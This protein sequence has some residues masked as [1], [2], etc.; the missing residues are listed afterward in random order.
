MTD[1]SL[2]ALRMRLTGGKEVVAETDAVTASQRRLRD[3]QGKFV[4]GSQQS[5]K[6]TEKQAAAQAKLAKT[7]TSLRTVGSAMTKYVS[8]PLA[9]IGVASGVMALDFD[10]SMRNVNSIAQLPEK[11]FISL[12]KQVL[13]LA[14]PTAQAPKTLAEGLYDLV[15]SGFTA[16]E[17]IRILH[18][19][20]LAASAGLTT[21]E[22]STKA[23]AASLNAYHLPAQKA[24]WVS[25]TLFET[26]NR[27]VLTFDELARSIG[28]VLP[29]ASQLNVPLNQ[30]GAALST[31][32][33]EGL[34]SAEAVTRTK[35]VLVTLIKPGKALTETLEGM[36][37]SGEELVKK[38]G[39]QG[40]L[41]AIVGTTKGG[42]AEIAELFP[43]I[44]ALGG[45]LALVGKNAGFAQKDLAAFKDTTGATN[46]VLNEQEKSFGFKL[47]RSWAE[48]QKVLIELGED[49]LPIVV[50]F[51]LELA[52]AGASVVQT[53][54]DLPGPLQK[55][56]LGIATL[57]AL[58]GPMIL[59]ASSTINVAKAL[60]LLSTVSGGG[61][62]SGRGKTMKGL[63]ARGA[64]GIGG[65]L[66]AQSA[67]GAIGGDLGNWVSSA[68][69][70]AATGFAL[71]GPM[72]AA[73]GGAVGGVAAA[74][75]K[76]S[77]ELKTVSFEQ[78]RLAGSSKDVVNFMHRQRSA[79]TG[80]TVAEHRV[81]G[82]LKRR[83]TAT[84][85][86]KSAQRHL[87]AVVSEY[88]PHSRAAIHAEARLT[89]LTNQHRQ[90]IKRL[91]SA[92]RLRGVALSA[93]KTATNVTV[94][95]ER[96]RITVLTELRDRQAKLYTSSK[97]ANPQS[98]KTRNLA[99]NLLGTEKNLSKAVQQH[100]QTLGD[101]AAKGG[102]AY[103]K[104]LQRAN[105]ESVRAGGSMKA[106]NLKAERL[107]TT[108]K[109]L[110]EL[111]VTVPH[112][113]AHGGRRHPG[114]NA[115]GTNWWR[116]G[117]TYLAE[118]G[119]ELVNL[120]RGSR[121]L[122]AP[123]TRKALGDLP[124]ARIASEAGGGGQRLLAPIIVK[125]GRK[126]L[127]EVQAEVE[128]DAKARL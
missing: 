113:E 102:Q 54:A 82:A 110:A 47:Q 21:T 83:K 24:G 9:A 70:G 63:L 109:G 98:E 105:Q 123:A 53:F 38:K 31:M 104:F 127:A 93:Y 66:A 11:R 46:K 56:A 90:A 12:K 75:S 33:K 18:K 40:A 29:F 69:T 6:A 88:G 1:A 2:I 121:V 72:G 107:T 10:R 67:G 19:S 94:L 4:K 103:A 76:V 37:V 120:P 106:L 68:G 41:E 89:G 42:K 80:L 65:T 101:A 125:V 124:A 27:G 34:S 3:E 5:T 59:F 57:A 95:A 87:S 30:V 60:G 114:H 92:E 73:V 49:L 14:G 84:D 79:S 96:H 62:L 122:P 108:L 35:N 39:L 97:Q 74:Y 77:G 58:A 15:S 117:E 100:S 78:R 119:P 50:P 91:Q 26:V 128:A 8:L 48:L 36:G 23:V 85:Q 81:A 43:N 32:T 99:N 111:E 118:R 22:V 45:V 16:D 7:A 116:G 13:D 28:D 20:A 55:T 86:L 126:V 112:V 115:A 71:G 64:V 17:S 61:L 44:R 51:V 25:D 52:H